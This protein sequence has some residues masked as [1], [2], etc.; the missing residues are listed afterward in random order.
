M[1]EPADQLPA[2]I[3]PAR[4]GALTPLPDGQLIPALIADAG[5]QA[6]WQLRRLLHRQHPQPEQAPTNERYFSVA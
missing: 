3:E 5:G 6:A 1:T 4:P 2:I